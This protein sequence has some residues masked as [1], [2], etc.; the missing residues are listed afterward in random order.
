MSRNCVHC[1]W[2]T[3]ASDPPGMGECRGGPPSVV[4]RDIWN[5]PVWPH[6]EADDWC[7]AFRER[8]SKGTN[9]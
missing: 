6:T 7:G 9:P 8:E 1:K 4:S 3:N 5:V 2:W